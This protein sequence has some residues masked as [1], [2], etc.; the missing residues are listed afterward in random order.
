MI[1]D[2]LDGGRQ[3]VLGDY[4]VSIE[5][6]PGL[7]SAD[8][9]RGLLRYAGPDQVSNCGSPEIVDEHRPEAGRRACRR[10]AFAEQSDRAAFTVKHERAFRDSYS[11]GALDDLGQL[12]AERQHPALFALGV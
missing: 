6:R 3:I 11:F 7:V 5:N 1:P 4:V 2:A 8:A 9:H 10:P 12:A